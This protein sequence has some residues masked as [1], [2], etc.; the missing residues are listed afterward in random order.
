MIKKM[1]KIKNVKINL[2]CKMITLDQKSNVIYIHINTL[3]G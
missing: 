1:K 3:D 2:K